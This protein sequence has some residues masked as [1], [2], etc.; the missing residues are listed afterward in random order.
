M[1]L[2]QFLEHH[3]STIFLPQFAFFIIYLSVIAI[4]LSN[5]EIENMIA[6]N[7]ILNFLALII[8]ALQGRQGTYMYNSF[9]LSVVMMEFLLVY[10]FYIHEDLLHYLHL[11][12]EDL[13]G[14]INISAAVLK[15]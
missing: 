10:I 1:Q 12:T 5:L 3:F 14:K 7:H 2:L 13:S 15:P 9:H 8:F 11:T 6:E 4:F